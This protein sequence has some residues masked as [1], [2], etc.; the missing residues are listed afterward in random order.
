MGPG[1]RTVLTDVGEE[2]PLAISNVW[3]PPMNEV[4]RVLSAI[5]GGDPHAAEQL[6]PLVYDDLPQAGGAEMAQEKPG[7][8]VEAPD[9]LDSCSLKKFPKNRSA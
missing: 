1:F 8:T 5:E 9:G 4:T 7:Q 2:I 3:V 6:L